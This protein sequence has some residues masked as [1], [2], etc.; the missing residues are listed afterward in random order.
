M[1]RH[2][3]LQRV[4]HS[5]LKRLPGFEIYIALLRLQG[6]RLPM[7]TSRLEDNLKRSAVHL[8][9]VEISRHAFTF[10][11]ISQV[12]A[13]QRLTAVF[14]EGRFSDGLGIADYVAKQ[15]GCLLLTVQC[16][17]VNSVELFAQILPV[18]RQNT[19]LLA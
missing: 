16:S 7:T 9:K 5:S 12:N 17:A 6:A 13:D 19:N 14:I 11:M 1:A 3:R 18:S 15:R 8:A 10:S 2:H 4:P